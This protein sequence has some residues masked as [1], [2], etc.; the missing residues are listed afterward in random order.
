M[1]AKSQ[2]VGDRNA[3]SVL[4][5]IADCANEAGYSWY[6]IATIAET[7]EA[8][9]KTVERGLHY[10]ESKNI[11]TRT[12]RTK[13]HGKFTSKGTQINIPEA[14]WQQIREARS[15]R[16]NRFRPS[17]NLTDGEDMPT[18]KLTDGEGAPSDNLSDGGEFQSVSPS[19]NLTNGQNDA[20]TISNKDVFLE[21]SFDK[22]EELNAQNACARDASAPE[23]ALVVVESVEVMHAPETLFDFRRSFFAAMCQELAVKRLPNK[24]DWLEPAFYAHEEGYSSA[25]AAEVFRLMRAQR[26]R[27]GPVSPRDWLKNLS[28]LENLRKEI[29]TQEDEENGLQPAKPKTERDKRGDAARDRINFGN[30]ANDILREQGII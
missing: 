29:Q 26:W 6:A 15:I 22:E 5:E 27:H 11:I 30:R 21:P 23:S 9:P 8:S 13:Q 12:E 19:D 7:L 14:D 25:H 17:D 20:L 28:N 18:D 24:D 1:W 10:L 2:K 16:R 4:L 3:K